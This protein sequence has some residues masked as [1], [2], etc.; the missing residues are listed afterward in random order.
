MLTS[1]QS[2]DAE[3]AEP[4]D[5]GL[6]VSL[7]FL[8]AALRRRWRTWVGVALVAL[9]LGVAW[10]VLVPPRSTGTVTLFLAHEPDV[11]PEV[12]MATDVS[13]LQTRSVAASLTDRLG[14]DLTPEELQETVVATAVTP[15]VLQIDVDAPDPS[16]A[17][18]RAATLAEVFLAFRGEQLR[19]GSD[20][21]VAGNRDRVER[22][23]DQAAVL[24]DEFERL[25]AQGEGGEGEAA[26]VLTE[27]SRLTEEIVRL[28]QA[29]E[30]TTLETEAVLNAS[31]VVDEAAV[32]PQSAPARWVLTLGSVLVGGLGA[33]VGLV[34][35][36]ALT[37][38]RLRR[39][40]EVA[41][42][43]GVPVAASVTRG[44]QDPRAARTAAIR[45][46]VAAT[47]EGDR[48]VGIAAVGRTVDHE[49]LAA[50]AALA[51]ARSGSSVLV[52]DLGERGRM[53]R[54]VA[55]LSRRR[56]G[57]SAGISVVRPD[58]TRVPAPG[59]VRLARRGVP[60]TE[61]DPVRTAYDAADVVLA[62]TEV[63]PT[64]DLD[65]LSAWVDRVVLV[66]EAG[67]SS[68]ERLRSV[69]ELVRATGP[70]PTVAVLTGADRTDESLGLVGTGE[71]GGAVAEPTA[72]RSAP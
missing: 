57:T 50:E 15:Q 35:V 47:G 59:P 28:Q 4:V 51:L 36:T 61:D 63:E 71:D 70:R 17:R 1:W 55:A 2:A 8:L 27:R 43:L 52:A 18:E 69:A 30:E 29:N 64:S 67:G 72:R 66:V 32:V 9:L 34:L 42:A 21:I 19:A 31:A 24:T 62:L 25:T 10:L 14:L 53:R 39:R 12:A 45:A 54:T 38:T 6:L 16:A 11:Q 26:G 46:I 65:E 48:R 37:S 41:L 68:A 58:R 23:E 22:I 7:H 20:A 40:D 60:V 56:P 13:L 44:A 5:T 49:R 3:R 33:G